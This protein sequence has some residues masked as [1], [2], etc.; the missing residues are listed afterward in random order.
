MRAIVNNMKNIDS[1][2]LVLSKSA[3]KSNIF[4]QYKKILVTGYFYRGNLG[5]DLFLE[6][7]KFIASR[8][9]PKDIFFLDFVTVDDL[10]IYSGKKDFDIVII[11]GGDVFVDYFLIEL[12]S[13]FGKW[14]FSGQ[15]FAISVGIPY[16]DVVL[17]YTF[18]KMSLVICRAKK[19]ELFLHNHYNSKNITYFP[20]ISIY[21]PLMFPDDSTKDILKNDVDVDSCQCELFKRKRV[22]VFPIRNIYKNNSFYNKIIENLASCLENIRDD[23]YEIYLIP[24]CNFLTQNDSLI[25]NDIY[26]KLKDKKYIHNISKSY[27]AKEMFSIFKKLDFAICM[28]YHAHMFAIMA[29]T[30]LMSFNTTRKVRNLLN[31]VSLDNVCYSLP[32]DNDCLPIDLSKDIFMQKWNILVSTQDDIKIKMSDFVKFIDKIPEFEN[33]ILDAI[34]KPTEKIS[35]DEKK[36]SMKSIPVVIEC[37]LDYIQTIPEKNDC[38]FKEKTVKSLV[39][40]IQ[41][42]KTRFYDLIKQDISKK[43]QLE[44]AEFL[45]ALV[46][47]NLVATPYPSYHYG[48]SRKILTENFKVKDDFTW[49]YKD[50]LKNFENNVIYIDE[51]NFKPKLSLFNATYVGTNDF[52]NSHRSGWKYVLNN[53][54]KFHSDTH[55]IILD[56]YVDRTFHWAHD[57]YK[58]TKVIPFKQKWCG[59]IH[60]T[61]DLE[62]SEYNIP[63]LFKKPLFIESLSTCFALFTLSKDLAVK[64][65]KILDENNYQN[66]CVANFIHPTECSKHIFTI[67]KFM[68]N[69]ERKIVNIG[70]WLRDHYLIYRLMINT[71]DFKK[72][73][74]LKKAHLKGSSM[75]HYFKPENF[76]LLLKNVD[77]DKNEILFNFKNFPEIPENT[78]KFVKGFLENVYNDWKSVE[79][80]DSLSNN[81][82][83]ILLSENIVFLNLIDASTV[84]TVIEC[85]VRCTPILVNKLPSIVEMLGEEYPFY[86][87]SIFEASEKVNNLDL[88][89]KTFRYLVCLNKK[90]FSMEYFLN[91]I[92]NWFKT[93]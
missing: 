8:I 93:V 23:N 42:N 38:T 19:D 34:A 20:D 60:H 13:I 69:K 43:R 61:F 89:K 65:R 81:N 80:I 67:E 88:I 2:S 12:F 76:S 33:T 5:D 56:N 4:K 49:V 90:Q 79:T 82:Y 62:Y 74:S 85:I 11:A 25:I 48:M 73:I 1:S 51:K 53:L 63:N 71:R 27:S 26:E 22:G 47:F 15:I 78:N 59:F 29:N 57:V 45:S 14:E 31:D 77:S 36:N 64:L 41:E 30:P 44:I 70:G 40:D 17:N 58:F 9:F 92:E 91:S 84:N 75:N 3:S 6:V 87:S 18:E 10:K 37:L 7:W 83:D 24:F 52:N 16:R 21:L 46:C 54:M 28:R 86:Y 68:N 72:F 39:L 35:L 55:S 50:N 32:V 66:I